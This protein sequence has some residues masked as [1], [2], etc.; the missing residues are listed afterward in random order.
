MNEWASIMCQSCTSKFDQTQ[1]NIPKLIAKSSSPCDASLLLMIEIRGI[2][3]PSLACRKSRYINERLPSHRIVH[4]LH[5]LHVGISLSSCR[6]HTWLWSHGLISSRP[7]RNDVE[8]YSYPLIFVYTGVVLKH[9][10]RR[11]AVLAKDPVGVRAACHRSSQS[12]GCQVYHSEKTISF[13]L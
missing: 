3:A 7:R 13:A 2:G 6:R 8:F 9:F 4:R 10:P 11:C 1:Q 5:V 12:V